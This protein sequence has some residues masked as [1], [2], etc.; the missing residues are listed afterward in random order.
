MVKAIID[1]ID[2]NIPV[3]MWPRLAINLLLVGPNGID[4]RI[5]NRQMV[6]P[7]IT[8]QGANVLLPNWDLILPIV[9]EMFMN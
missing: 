9:Q 1:G 5:I 3:W 4:S 2:T 8:E 7:I 6:T